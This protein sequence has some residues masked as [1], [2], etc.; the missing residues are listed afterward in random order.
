MDG[1]T[2]NPIPVS[3]SNTA[4]SVSNNFIY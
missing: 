2:I 1:K 4:V 3:A